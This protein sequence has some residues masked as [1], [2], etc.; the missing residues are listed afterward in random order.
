[1]TDEQPRLGIDFGRVIQ[2]AALEPGAADT[3]FLSGGHD[4][5]MNTPPSPDAFEILPR[6][7][8]RFAGHAWVISTCGPRVQQRTLDWLDHH[9]FYRV[10]KRAHCARLGITHMIDDRLEVHDAL[11]GL[12]T[13]LYLFGAQTEPAPMWVRHVPTWRDTE[14]AVI[15]T[16]AQ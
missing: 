10:D 16:L 2:G 15:A 8:D 7:V 13:H 3:A 1:M 6:L 11:R 5:A 12:V 4:A 14:S 9:D